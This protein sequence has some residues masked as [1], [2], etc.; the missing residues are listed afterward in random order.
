LR[1]REARR[2]REVGREKTMEGRQGEGG[3]A[4]RKD[5][6]AS[7]ARRAEVDIQGTQEEG[8]GGAKWAKE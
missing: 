4:E 8:G 7:G 2:K 5:E 1:G 3:L 6:G